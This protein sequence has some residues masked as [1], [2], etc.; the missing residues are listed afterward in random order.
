MW[1]FKW[2]DPVSLGKYSE[3]GCTILRKD[4]NFVK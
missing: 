1:P 3:N 4:H 2:I